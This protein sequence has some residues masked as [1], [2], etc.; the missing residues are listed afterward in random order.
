MALTRR[1]TI[2][3]I[4]IV[5]S[6]FAAFANEPLPGEIELEN[7]EV[8][9]GFVS[10]RKLDVPSRILFYELDSILKQPIEESK[11]IYGPNELK[12]FTYGDEKWYSIA[13]TK[14]ELGY[15]ASYFLK[16]LD[17]TATF[18]L[19]GGIVTGEGCNCSGT[20]IN[21]S[22]HWI[23]LD[24]LSGQRLILSKKRRAKIEKPEWVSAFF[25]GFG[26]EISSS[27]FVRPKKVLQPIKEHNL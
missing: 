14:K 24:T 7:G 9:S 17:T 18:A 21:A 25:S 8:L 2:C 3:L 1:I 16:V 27:T 6:A 4:S 22:Y 20:K 12:S 10:Y 26:Y 15:Q 19:L 13:F 5:F 11:T 23:L